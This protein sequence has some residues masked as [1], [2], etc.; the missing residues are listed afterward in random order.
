MVLGQ[1]F[2]L[3]IAGLG[4]GLLASAGTARALGG[5]FP[6]GVGGDGRTDD[7]AFLLVALAVLV[8]MLLAAYVPAHRASRINP[9]DALRHE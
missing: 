9:T 6:G 7:V 3:A 4:A 8:V 5:I 1:G 2:V